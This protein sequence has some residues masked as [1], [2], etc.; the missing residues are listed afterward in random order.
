MTMR[1]GTLFCD[2]C[3]RAAPRAAVRCT[4]CFRPL[5]APAS[6]ER[7]GGQAASLHVGGVAAPMRRNSRRADPS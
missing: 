3:N 4:W 7:A 6:S 5:H 1:F 2:H